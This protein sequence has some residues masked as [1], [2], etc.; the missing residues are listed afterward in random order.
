VVLAV[1]TRVFLLVAA[2]RDVPGLPVRVL[3]Q[4]LEQLCARASRQAAGAGVGRILVGR[5]LVSGGEQKVP[6]AW[7]GDASTRRPAFAVDPIAGTVR[8]PEERLGLSRGVSGFRSVAQTLLVKA[9]PSR[10]GA[11]RAAT[12]IV[13][14]RTMPQTAP[15]TAGSSRLPTTGSPVSVRS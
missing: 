12:T 10:P 14:V 2:R 6:R 11:P 1:L 9:A 3:S 13:V 8:L 4:H 5:V 15:Y 7:P